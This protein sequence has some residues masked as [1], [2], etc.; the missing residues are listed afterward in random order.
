MLSYWE[1]REISLAWFEAG[2]YAV[3]AKEDKEKKTTFNGSDKE[4]TEND[5]R[6]RSKG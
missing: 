3:W 1:T 6:A 5:M 4:A 2:D